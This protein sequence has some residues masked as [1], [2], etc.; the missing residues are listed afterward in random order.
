M[1]NQSFLCYS[2]TVSQ[3]CHH[4]FQLFTSKILRLL[5][6]CSKLQHMKNAKPDFGP[7]T[8]LLYIIK[9]IL[10][11]NTYV[12]SGFYTIAGFEIH[13]ICLLENLFHCAIL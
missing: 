6:F 2:I 13:I 4:T 11:N 12:F 1:K 8:F 10:V 5:F 9:V 7:A 3:A